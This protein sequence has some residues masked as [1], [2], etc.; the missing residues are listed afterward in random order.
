MADN[1]TLAAKEIEKHRK[2]L[3]LLSE[4]IWNHPELNF[5]EHTAHR[6]LTDYLEGKGFAVERGYAGVATAFRA[7]FGA[8]KPNVCVICEYDALP[9][10]G[11]ACGHNLIAE[12]GV[13]AGL[14]AKAWL[15][16]SGTQATL[17][18]MGTPAEEGGGGKIVM[19]EKEAFTDVDV[20]MMAHPERYDYVIP[21]NNAYGQVDVVYKGKAAHAAAFPWEGVNALDAAVMAYTNVSALRQQMK[22]SWRVHGV[23]KNG[24]VKPNIIPEQSEI[25]YC[26]RAPS[27]E[28]RKVLVGKVVACFEAAASASGCSVEVKHYEREYDSILTNNILAKLYSSNLDALHLPHKMEMEAHWSSDMGNLSRVVPSI[29][30]CYSIGS[31]EANHTR[32]FRDVANHPSS[33]SKTLQIATSLA[34]TCIDVFSGGEELVKKIAE[35]LK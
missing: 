24:G 11:H 8:G 27:L 34:F 25:S 22:P 14:G 19:I 17:T 20:A 9:E 33:H 23:I 31:G 32:D 18:V 29:H 5:E 21:H 16:A 4:E 10:I 6:L 2:E 1:K 28:E 30:P 13:A 3:Q 12:A 15:E 35:E 7:R 26:I